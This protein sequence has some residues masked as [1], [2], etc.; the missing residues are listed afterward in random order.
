MKKPKLTLQATQFTFSPADM[1]RGKRPDL[2]DLTALALK[3][4]R[5]EWK[6]VEHVDTKA[7]GSDFRTGLVVVVRFNAG[8]KK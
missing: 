3:L 1:A 2:D 7:H 6:Q 4:A 8:G 5:G